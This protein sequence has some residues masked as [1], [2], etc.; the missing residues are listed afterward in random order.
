MVDRAVRRLVSQRRSPI[1]VLGETARLRA[2][3]A[4]LLPRLEELFYGRERDAL[5]SHVDTFVAQGIPRELAQWATRVMYSFGLLD[6]VELAEETGSPLAEVADVYFL[7]S[8]H[9]NIDALLLAHLRATPRRPVAE[10]CPDGAAL[11]P[12][13]RVDGAD[14][15]RARQHRP[16]QES[17]VRVE[18]WER[19]NAS[20]IQRATNAMGD[21]DE[22]HADLA[23]LSVLLRQIRTLV[24]P[25]A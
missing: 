25:T 10:P 21:F 9:F 18:Q 3:V 16:A 13:R 22:S 20:I 12:V 14:Q 4:A 2:G 8:E 1:D 15:G 5:L 23:A 7:L 11:R 19:K 17:K 24:S 6:I